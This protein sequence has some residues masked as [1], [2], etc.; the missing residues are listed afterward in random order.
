MESNLSKQKQTDRLFF[1]VL[2]VSF[3]LQVY[4]ARIGLGINDEHFYTTLGYR[5][6]LGDALF[7]DDWHIAQ[8]ISVFVGPPVWLFIR[9]TGSTDGIILFMRLVYAVFTS[10]V[11]T[12]FYMHVRKRSDRAWLAALLYLLFTPFSIMALSY[13]T[14]SVGFVILGLICYESNDDETKLYLCGV[15]AACA[16]LNTPYLIILYAVLTLVMIRKPALVSVSRWGK[17]TAGALCTAGLFLAFVLSRASLAQVMSGLPHLV[18]P[19]HQTGLVSSLIKNAG[20]LFRFFHV[21]IVVLAIE[22]FAALWVKKNASKRRDIFLQGI[23]CLNTILILAVV[24]VI[25][26]Q[27]EIGGAAVILIPL[28][29]C[30]LVHMILYEWSGEDRLWYWVSAVHAFL[31][32]ISSNVG[33]R[34][35]S[36]PLIVAVMVTVLN[37]A[38]P[39]SSKRTAS[40]C[41][42]VWTIVFLA[43]KAFNVYDGSGDYG[44][45]VRNGPLKGL[46]DSA[47]AVQSYDA[48][49]GDMKTIDR[50]KEPSV[51]LVTGNTWEYLALNKQIA[52]DSTYI[53]FWEKEQYLN[54]LQEYRILHDE[55]YPALVYLDTAAAPYEM[56]E[57]DPWLLTMEK[58][59]SLR[60]GILYVLR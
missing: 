25:R 59:D 33:P 1:L 31:I 44:T 32:L 41:L 14:M 15:F 58:I 28:A 20:R 30:G 43:V 27:M 34:S 4:K 53:Y 26:Q 24:G 36:G 39:V 3:C 49:L 19:S 10:I 38:K 37:L 60:C 45:R 42:A 11:G 16:V 52:A 21:G 23:L 50:M 56:K 57:T 48:L 9:L 22:P 40:A 17:I 55:K 29:L 13:N 51:L 7:F 2:A 12:V 35:F 46:F 6:Y 54:S 8:L 47:E 18:D 5:L